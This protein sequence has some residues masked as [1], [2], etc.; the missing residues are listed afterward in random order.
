MIPLFYLR[1]LDGSHNTYNFYYHIII[2]SGKKEP[3][4]DQQR[5]AVMKIFY[6]DIQLEKLPGK[7]DIENAMRRE[8]CLETRGWLNIK[9]FVRNKITQKRSKKL[10]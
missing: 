5:T 7:A 4:T 8:P 1:T 10:F 3:W 6:R 2:L 9:D